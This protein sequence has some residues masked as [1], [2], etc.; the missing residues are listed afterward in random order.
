MS[1]ASIKDSKQP[2]IRAGS[3]FDEKGYQ[4]SSEKKKMLAAVPLI[5][6]NPVRR[7]I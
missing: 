3:W 6:H 7:E 2:F 4:N 5:N 1:H